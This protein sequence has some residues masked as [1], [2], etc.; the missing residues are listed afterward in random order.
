MEFLDDSSGKR[1]HPRHSM[2]PDMGYGTR[3]ATTPTERPP[4]E[5]DLLQD[6]LED[7]VD[8]SVLAP[9]EQIRLLQNVESAEASLRAALAEIPETARRLLE[10]WRDRRDRGLVT[11]ALS[12]WHRDGSNRNVHKLIDQAFMRMEASLRAFDLSASGKLAARKHALTALAESVLDAEVALPVLLEILEGLVDSNELRRDKHCRRALG[13]AVESRA[14]LTDSKNLFINHNLRLV[15][16]CA[17]NYRNQGVPFLD[18]IQEGNIGLI[19]AVEK[20]DYRR[21]YKFSTYAIWWIEQSLVRSVANDSRAVRIPSPLLDQRRRLKQREGAERAL[22]P[23]EP[24][25][26]DLIDGL[27]L[28]PKD[29]DDLRRSLE[30]EVSTQVTV[31][32]TE[33]LTLEETLVHENEG[34]WVDSFDQHSLSRHIR[35]IIPTLSERG[36]RVIEA[37]FGLWGDSPRTLHDIGREL[38][39][40]RERVRQIEKQALE[41]LRENPVAES[42]A[43]ELGCL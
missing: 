10:R 20:F 17:K 42:I 9:E 11:G 18:L 24:T 16:R 19:R 23:G 4:T 6:Y 15:I 22:T 25:P 29:I 34:D 26:M 13:R 7:I 43:S 3:S 36:Q 28:D 39:V 41:Q 21:G 30:A 14:R 33:N 31:G 38:G 37:R 2:E 35:Q 5:R 32:R 40:S 1:S 27:A 12:R 8:M